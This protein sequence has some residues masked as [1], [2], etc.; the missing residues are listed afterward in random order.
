MMP[1]TTKPSTSVDFPALL[2]SSCPAVL[3]GAFVV[4]L[5]C[6]TVDHSRVEDGIGDDATLSCVL[7]IIPKL[8]PL[9][10]VKK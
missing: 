3:E 10:A 1:P 7:R 5:Y 6:V 2:D 9:R 8:C 4:V